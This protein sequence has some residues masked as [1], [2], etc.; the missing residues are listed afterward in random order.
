MMRRTESEVRE[1]KAE[2]RGETSNHHVLNDASWK[3]RNHSRTTH[4][5]E[6]IES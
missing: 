4:A 1:M 6:Y 5:A 2:K 3:D